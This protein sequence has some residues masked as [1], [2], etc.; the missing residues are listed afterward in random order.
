MFKNFKIKYSSK[1]Q[2]KKCQVK[3]CTK[4]TK[5]TNRNIQRQKTQLYDFDPLKPFN[6]EIVQTPMALWHQTNNK[7]KKVFFL[8]ILFSSSGVQSFFLY[9][10]DFELL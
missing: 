10:Q 5:L 6:P 9:L 1:V 3:H 7:N 4:L 2:V 8:I